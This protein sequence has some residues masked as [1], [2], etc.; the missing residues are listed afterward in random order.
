MWTRLRRRSE[1]EDP[2]IRK[3][4]RPAFFLQALLTEDIPPYL[5]NQRGEKLSLSDDPLAAK[6]QEL[7]ETDPASL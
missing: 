6:Y 2:G 3:R 4:R 7:L 1:E 5:V